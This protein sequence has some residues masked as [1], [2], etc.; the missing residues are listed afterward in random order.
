[1]A[2][3]RFSIQ[4]LVLLFAGLLVAG[5]GGASATTTA[6]EADDSE[7]GSDSLPV[8]EPGSAGAFP[9]VDTGQATCYDADRTISPPA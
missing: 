4:A 1:M 2:N 6:A 5:C 9:L 7:G 3:A 8:S